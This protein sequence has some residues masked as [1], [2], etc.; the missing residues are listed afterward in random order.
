MLLDMYGKQ[1]LVH[2]KMLLLFIALAL[3]GLICSPWINFQLSVCRITQEAILR[4]CTNFQCCL[5]A[6]CVSGVKS[7]F[8]FHVYS[9]LPC[10]LANAIETGAV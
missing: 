9:V 2:K 4:L 8:L 10:Y 6:P 1:L 5:L 3:T 7:S